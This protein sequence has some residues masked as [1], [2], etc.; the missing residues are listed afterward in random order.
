VAAAGLQR[1]QVYQVLAA[2]ELVEQR[3]LAV[4]AVE[5]VHQ[6]RRQIHNRILEQ[7]EQ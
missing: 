5:W 6:P 1:H 4:A 2:A 7:L 3:A